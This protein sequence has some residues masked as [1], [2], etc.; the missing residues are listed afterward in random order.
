MYKDIINDIL[1]NWYFKI[2]KNILFEFQIS[3]YAIIYQ[4]WKKRN[5]LTIYIL[6]AIYIL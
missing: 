6:Y 1:K 3:S 5:L 4:I 2:F